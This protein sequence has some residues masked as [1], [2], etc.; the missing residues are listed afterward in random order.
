MSPITTVWQLFAIAA[1]P[2]LAM[3]VGAME[4]TGIHLGECPSCE[5]LFSNLETGAEG[6]LSQV[7]EIQERGE[8]KSGTGMMGIWARAALRS[9]CDFLSSTYGRETCHFTRVGNGTYLLF[10]PQAPRHNN[11]TCPCDTIDR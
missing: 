2:L 9:T 7:V 11:S 5:D 4:T 10:D 3:V 6:R 8:P 1:A